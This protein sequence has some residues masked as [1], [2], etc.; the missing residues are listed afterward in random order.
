MIDE[1]NKNDDNDKESSGKNKRNDNKD[2]KASIIIQ[3]QS[4]LT[5]VMYQH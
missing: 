4:F 3:L 5:E 1:N 2:E